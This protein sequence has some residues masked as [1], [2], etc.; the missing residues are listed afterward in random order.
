MPLEIDNSQDKS[1][2]DD[3]PTS[4]SSLLLAASQ[5]KQ[6]AKPEP[7][8]PG[9]LEK[10]SLEA[11]VIGGGMLD[12]TI[13][14]GREALHDPTSLLKLG[15]SALI[16]TGLT[17]AHGKKGIIGAGAKVVGLG[18]GLAFGK[19]V[20]DQ[21]GEIAHLASVTWKS[22]QN[23][24][25]Y[26][27]RTAEQIGPFI[28]DTA[29]YTAGGLTGVKLGRGLLSRTA[30]TNRVSEAVPTRDSGTVE[31]NRIEQG[32]PF[33][34]NTLVKISADVP[35]GRTIQT[36]SEG[37]GKVEVLTLS[38]GNPGGNVGTAVSV[39][40]DG[41]LVTNRH[42]V[43]DAISIT[44][45]D[46]RG[47]AHPA[48]VSKVSPDREVDLAI[49]Q[50]ENPFSNVAFKPVEFFNA[51][52]PEAGS[53]IAIVGYPNGHNSLFVSTGIVH[54]S[55]YHRPDMPRFNA[56]V[57][58]GNSGSAIVDMQGK[59]V[60][61][62]KS[63]GDLVNGSSARLVDLLL[64][65]GITEQVAAPTSKPIAPRSSISTSF[66]VTD[67]EKAVLTLEGIFGAPIKS[68]LPPDLFHS[69]IRRTELDGQELLLKSEYHPLT[70][71]LVVK[72]I[73]LG[74]KPLGDL[75][76]PGTNLPV[77]SAELKL[78]FSNSFRQ[79]EMK[80]INDPMGLL[81]KG[82]ELP[83]KKPSYLSQLSPTNTR[84][85]SSIFAAIRPYT[86]GAI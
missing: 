35:L 51:G 1:G 5:D 43:E 42:V 21:G 8:Q 7:S 81:L 83:G 32:L 13:H 31:F 71:E 36:V 46:G 84:Q 10:L 65:K 41:Q 52:T 14:N 75:R 39:T 77:A 11:S 16:G 24:A 2:K 37:V 18:L 44:V 17:L 40:R 26:R 67:S 25:L 61:V 59:L 45:F 3:Q 62:M 33:Q 73:A 54:A 12:G 79:A 15:G 20:V 66:E 9:V 6:P 48:R 76:F 28:V 60:A 27:A 86:R 19:E 82:L 38:N 50:L 68:K 57:Q 55:K 69:R 58:P 29:I 80:S 53:Q 85:G 49:L 34:G 23:S 47:Q 4:L 63:Q 74:G 64:N 30:G 56:N 22:P 70:T 72:P 78:S